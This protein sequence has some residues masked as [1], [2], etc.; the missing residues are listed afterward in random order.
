MYLTNSTTN[1]RPKLLDLD[2]VL[3]KVYELNVLILILIGCTITFVIGWII[4][5]LFMLFIRY[6]CCGC[7]CIPGC[8][9]ST[10]TSTTGHDENSI[11][12]EP[13]A[14]AQQQ[15]PSSIIP[16]I[17]PKERHERK[18]GGNN[19]TR[20]HW[21][22]STARRTNDNTTTGRRPQPR[23]DTDSAETTPSQSSAALP[24]ATLVQLY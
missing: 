19:W 21:P 7:K 22:F 13:T 14:H 3:T 20:F 23:D 2:N 12:E 18:R 15:Q 17:L 10:A 16:Q 24:V 6:C 9:D 5:F 11:T 1:G 4:K 8:G